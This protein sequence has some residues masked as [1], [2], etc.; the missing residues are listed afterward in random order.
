[1]GSSLLMA[2]FA[3]ACGREAGSL[4]YANRGWPTNEIL[5]ES[6]QQM[7]S[8]SLPEGKTIVLY[9]DDVLPAIAWHW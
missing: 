7:P 6:L 1:M 9:S 3:G 8:N 5:K 4:R 2:A